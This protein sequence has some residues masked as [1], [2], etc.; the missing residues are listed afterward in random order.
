M[1]PLKTL[2]RIL[3]HASPNGHHT[4]SPSGRPTNGALASIKYN[5]RDID[6]ASQVSGGSNNSSNN[7]TALSVLD[8][9]E[10]QLRERL[11]VLEEQ[12]FLVGEMVA[13]ASKRRRFD[14][15]SSLAQNV[16]DL[17]LEIDQITGTLGQLDFA[18]AYDQA[19]SSSSFLK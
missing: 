3:K 1:L 18:S 13:E 12:K 7:S 10:K 6:T 8:A 15:V 11:M 14:E 9:E 5:N 19:S 16:Q 17:N 4:P 2:P